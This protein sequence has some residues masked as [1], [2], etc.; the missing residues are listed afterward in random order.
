MSTTFD[1][2]LTGGQC[3]VRTHG[4]QR[5]PLPTRRW[6]GTADRA[7]HPADT[8]MAGLCDGPTIDLGCGPGRLVA[9]VARCGVT[10]LGVDISPLAVALTRA[11]GV[12]ALQRDIFGPLPGPG[13][14]SYALLADGN[15]GI[16]ADP[17]RLLTRIRHLLSGDGAV[18]VEFD[19]PGTGMRHQWVRLETRTTAGPW[20]RWARVGIE[21]ATPLAD[22]TGFRV[23][24]TTEVN[25]RHLARLDR[26]T[27]AKVR[28]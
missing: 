28:R 16:G 13:R 19:G 22:A 18:V 17:I 6:L 3:W 4:G 20:F 14:W 26:T 21:C 27:P 11:R 8:T 5:H 23:R 15:I 24:M 10:A 7:E 25:G 2:A 9:A 12:P 1:P